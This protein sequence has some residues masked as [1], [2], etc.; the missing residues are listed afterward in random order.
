MAISSLEVIQ[1]TYRLLGR[2][3]EAELPFQD[4]IDTAKDVYRGMMLDMKISN[5]NRT[6]QFSS[7]YTPTATEGVTLSAFG[8]NAFVVNIFPVKFEWRPKGATNAKPYKADVVSYE[9]LSDRYYESNTYN[10]TFVAFYDTNKIAFSEKLSTLSNREY[11]LVYE[12][13]EDVTWSAYT[14]TLDEIPQILIPYMQHKTAIKCLDIVSDVSPA[15]ADKRERLRV[16]LSKDYLEWEQRFTK[17]QRQ[18]RGN[19]KIRKMGYR[20]RK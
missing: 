15:W 6:I 1:G 19:K 3:A 18:R 12:D 8:L 7:W 9:A 17:W 20:P 5:R 13:T 11:R 16:V 14:D 10:E 2:P 4:I